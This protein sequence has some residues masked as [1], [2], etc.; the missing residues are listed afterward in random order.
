MSRDPE[1]AG[2]ISTAIKRFFRRN[3]EEKESRFRKR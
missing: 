3:P 1:E 2:G